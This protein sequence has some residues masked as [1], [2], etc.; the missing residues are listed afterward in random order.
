[1]IHLCHY[2][3][4]ILINIIIKKLTNKQKTKLVPIIVILLHVI[5][6]HVIY[7]DFHLMTK[8]KHNSGLA[9]YGYKHSFTHRR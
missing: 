5:Q 8:L 4:N 3:G 6:G 2:I 7:S 9:V 1:M